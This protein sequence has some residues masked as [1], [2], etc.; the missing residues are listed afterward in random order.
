M[1]LTQPAP[2]TL[3]YTERPDEDLVAAAKGGRESGNGILVEQV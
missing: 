1:A 2:A 3:D